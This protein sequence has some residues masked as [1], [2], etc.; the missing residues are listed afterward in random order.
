MQ[1]DW[2]TVAAQIV[3]FLVLVW[4]LQ[5]FLYRPIT[6]AIARR[7]ERIAAQVRDAEAKRAEAD[8]EAEAYRAKQEELERSRDQMLAEAKAAAEQ[9]RR[10][11]EQAAREAVDQRK[12][13]WLQQVEDQRAEFLRD[14]RQSS[15][16]H[17]Y[18]LARQALGDL[19]DAELEEQIVRVFLGKLAELDA[20]ATAKIS[21]E[22]RKAGDAVAVQSRFEIAANQ[23]TRITRAIR[24]QFLD[25]A[26]VTYRFGPEQPAGIELKAG[27]Q[28]V[29]WNLASYFDS[30]ESRLATE[31]DADL[32][33]AGASA[34]P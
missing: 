6:Q 17:F 28:T 3:N 32:A 20:D 34:E 31:L 18:A 27:G 11:L 25:T 19:A 16:Q 23:R 24:K 21:A 4:L 33:A 9:E 8:G 29:G 30:L 10:T 5:R 7:E 12:Q 15:V 13:E 2:L 26:E 1:V 22:A 14:L